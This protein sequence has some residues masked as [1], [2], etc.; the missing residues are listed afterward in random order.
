MYTIRE[1]LWGLIRPILLALVLAYFINPFINMLEERKIPRSVGILITYIFIIV[2]ITI[3]LVYLIPELIK[4]VRELMEKTPEYFETGNILFYDL[5]IRYQHSDLPEGIKNIINQNIDTIQNKIM[6]I[7]QNSVKSMIGIFYFIF[8]IVLSAVI[9]YYIV[10]DMDKF[11][12]GVISLIPKNIR[13]WVLQLANDIN[14]VLSGFVRGQLLVSAIMTVITAIGLNIIGMKYKLILSIIAGL[15][16]IIPYF[17]PILGAIP[18]VILALIDK[19]I[20]VLWVLF[21]YFIIQEIEG[22]V[23]SPKIVGNSIGLHPVAIMLAILA[24]GTFG[25]LMG[26]VLAVPIAGIVKV[27]G[28]R[29]IKSIV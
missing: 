27:L 9:A 13:G 11:K 28:N 24:G 12:K 20:K 14:L 16:N 17:G 2:S 1:P 3:V 5:M 18:A 19:P 15:T 8:D 7:L 23:I 25:G 6:Q 21:L 22:D 29:I 10:K 4:S 26:M